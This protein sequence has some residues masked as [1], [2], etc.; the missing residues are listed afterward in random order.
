M[1]YSNSTP[2]PSLN[3]PAGLGIGAAPA[4]SG[5]RPLPKPPGAGAGNSASYHTPSGPG[6]D[7]LPIYSGDGS[8]YRDEKRT[9]SG[10]SF[11]RDGMSGNGG[12]S[13]YTRDRS[14]T[15][16]PQTYGR[17]G[18]EHA[19]SPAIPDYAGEAS[20][21]GSRSRVP[22]GNMRPLPILPPQTPPPAESTPSTATHGYTDTS[23]SRSTSHT[24]H[25]TAEYGGTYET[26][27][28]GMTGWTPPTSASHGDMGYGRSTPTPPKS[29]PGYEGRDG[30]GRYS[31][32][33]GYEHSSEQTRAVPSGYNGYLSDS[34]QPPHRPDAVPIP[35]IQASSTSSYPDSTTSSS[36]HLNLEIL[37]RPL[38]EIPLSAGSAFNAFPTA[39]PHLPVPLSDEYDGSVRSFHTA[40]EAPSGMYDSPVIQER[41][42]NGRDDGGRG[43]TGPFGERRQGVPPIHPHQQE[44]RRSDLNHP[45]DPS[46]PRQSISSDTSLSQARAPAHWVQAKLQ[47]HQT[48][49]AEEEELEDEW[50]EQEVEEIHFFQPAL[51]SEAAVQL[52]DRVERGR[53]LKGGIAWVGSFT[54][55]DIVV[56]SSCPGEGLGKAGPAVSLLWAR[57]RVE[58]RQRQEVMKPV[59]VKEWNADRRPESG[60]ITWWSV[61][62]GFGCRTRYRALAERQSG[63]AASM[64]LNSLQKLTHRQQYK[65]FFP[66]TPANPILTGASP[67]S[68]RNH[69]RISS[70]SSRSTGTS[71]HYAI[72]LK[73][74]SGSWAMRKAWVMQKSFRK[75]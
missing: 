69:S 25:T 39:R 7:E 70:G 55:K 61:A 26:G 74:Y 57:E 51:L 73:T 19:L 24:G 6:G 53:H 13:D 41:R 72:P 29:A 50:D 62:L 54:G 60:G 31:Q 4:T 34:P 66:A 38:S 27:N 64:F 20:S 45:Q 15:V 68:W 16:T 67:Y 14:S 43:E 33:Q 2:I 8:G 75:G 17:N 48:V 56:S 44:P 40:S 22:S 49:D 52:R 63:R 18:T 10:A 36:S 37:N 32:V 47:I 71:S 59:L 9:P 11:G 1:P 58:A 35:T 3:H 30:G 12:T 23:A 5:R 46:E 42:G 21:S 65:A 28:S